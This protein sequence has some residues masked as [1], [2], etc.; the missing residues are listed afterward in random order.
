[1]F[2][3]A[4]D[5]MLGASPETLVRVDS[6]RVAARVLAGTAARGGDAEEDRWAASALAASAKDVA[7]HAF[8]V[9]SVLD[10]LRPHCGDV[11]AGEAFTLRLPNLW[12]LASE[13]E[14]TLDD[15]ADSL[16]LLDG[17]HPTAA[18]AG[19]P[20]PDAVQ[21]ISELEPFDR[22]RYA[23]PVGW[24]DGAGNGTWAIALRCARVDGAG[25]IT[26]YAG[27]G[28]VAGSDP[29]AELAETELKFRPV[30]EAF[31]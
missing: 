4:V 15:G 22:G 12:H 5:R 14:G 25:R 30:M 29:A 8:A 13:V 18:V 7:E 24:I 6:G 16:A 20:T 17:L 3:F 19:T 26:A 9:D 10:A 21:L 11:R 1:V 28:I 2:T 23:G 31:G 27:A